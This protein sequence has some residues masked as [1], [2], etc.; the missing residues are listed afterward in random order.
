MVVGQ[1]VHQASE[2]NL[3]FTQARNEQFLASSGCLMVM[4]SGGQELG[5]DQ[6]TEHPESVNQG[7]QV[8]FQD[9]G[10]I[11]RICNDADPARDGARP[12]LDIGCASRC[13]PE[14]AILRDQRSWLANCRCMKQ[15][16][17]L[18]DESFLASSRGQAFGTKAGAVQMLPL[19][20]Q[21]CV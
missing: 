5:V 10:G 9:V 8:K 4:D 12:L 19:T 11:K 20:S 17:K 14:F 13:A 16:S 15:A 7:L 18:F 6:F 1:A 2:R 21:V 3:A